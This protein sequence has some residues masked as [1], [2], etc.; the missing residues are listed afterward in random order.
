[1]IRGQSESGWISILVDDKKM[2]IVLTDFQRDKLEKTLKQRA[3]EIE[4]LQ[5]IKMAEK[6]K[7]EIKKL[8]APEQEAE[9][10]P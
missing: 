8:V 5:V 4:K 3:E 10:K 9:A 6:V 1:M 2:G 7:A